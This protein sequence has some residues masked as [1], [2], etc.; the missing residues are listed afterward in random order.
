[1]LYLMLVLFV[2]SVWNETRATPCVTQYLIGG[3]QVLLHCFSPI[4][5][6]C[7]TGLR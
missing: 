1:M 5:G 2:W 3:K 4:A 7:P 6:E